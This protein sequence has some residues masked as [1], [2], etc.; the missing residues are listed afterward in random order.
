M[1]HALPLLLLVDVQQRT[2]NAITAELAATT[3]II[4]SS[5]EDVLA[6]TGGTP[7]QRRP[8]VVVV[9]ETVTAPV[10]V[11]H[12]LRP[13]PADLAVAVTAVPATK[14]KLGVLPLLFSD[15]IVRRV[16][17]SRAARLMPRMVS[18]LLQ[19]LTRRRAHVATQAA[20]QQLLS[21]QA[22]VDRQLGERLLGQFLTQAPIGVLM[23]DGDAIIAW[24]QRAAEVLELREPDSVHRP[25]PDL[26]PE[27]QR[28]ALHHHLA[29]PGQYRDAEPDA[30]FERVRRDGTSQALRMAVQQVLDTEGRKRTL[31]LAEDVTDRLHAQRKL[32]E[33]TAHALLTA[34]VAAAMTAPGPLDERLH[35]C[36]RAATDRL[37]ADRVCVWNLNARGELAHAICAA[38]DAAPPDAS[39][40]QPT[41]ALAEHIVTS[42]RPHLDIAPRTDPHPSPP[43]LGRGSFAGFPLI[44]G[45]ELL[46]VLSITTPLALPGSVLTTLEN[47]ADQMAVGTQQD[48]LLNRLREATRALE[49]PLLPPRLPHMPDFDLGARYIPFSH[50]LHIGGDFYDAFTA[51]DG[52]HVLVLGDVCGKGPDAAAITGLVRHTLWTAAQHTS[53]PAYVLNLINTALRRQNTPFCTLVYVVIDTTRTPARLHIASAGHPAPLLRRADGDTAPLEA[54][55]PLLGVLDRPRHPVTE[56]ELRTGDTLV[57]YTDGLT[58]GAGAADQ[59]TPDDLAAIVAAV[60]PT[61]EHPAENIASVLMEDAHRWWGERLRDDLAVLTLTAVP[62]ATEPFPTSL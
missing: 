5:A 48:R 23:L 28:S 61:D 38:D 54:R 26:F 13:H 3:E 62:A 50:G 31:V 56:V 32:A 7:G 44:S 45:G 22:S 35:R 4:Q 29:V 37:G 12:S 20:A 8:T 46:G 25:V 17:G 59:R 39:L 53:D 33:R 55:G 19:Q 43:S 14:D 42:R 58:E 16:E 51:S 36:V 18:D 27:D 34:E 60:S 24:N 9:G 21:P 2:V 10:G 6:Y 1:N 49:R 15:D 57:L 11:V 40:C 41:R 30:V 52:R 47:I